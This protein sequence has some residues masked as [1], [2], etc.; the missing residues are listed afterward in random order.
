M[1]TDHKTTCSAFTLVETMVAL[2]IG[3]MVV[4]ATLAVY[5]RVRTASVV[6]V[7]QM[8]RHRLQNEIL[9]K[10][11]EDIDRLAAP[12]FE[13]T[14]KFANR[15]LRGNNEVSYASAEL[16]LTNSYYGNNDQKLL[17]EE[18][19]W[20]TA[21][22]PVEDTMILYRMHRGL[23]A[24]DPLFVGDESRRMYIPVAAGVTFFELRTQHGENILAAWTSDKLPKAV[25]IG[26]SFA[27]PVLLDG[28]GVG[29]ADDDIV[30]RTVAVDRS[31]IIPYEL[32]KVN[33]DLGVLD[34]AVTD[35]PNEPAD[36]TV[37]EAMETDADDAPEM[38]DET[39]ESDER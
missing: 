9:Q 5:Q 15:T 7:E 6:I 36:D 2:V 25:R 29:V 12:G 34:E 8:S 38:M 1:T 31:R 24:E 21:Y 11:A 18:V 37:D 22:D 17:Y 3:A 4:T 10:M 26:L 14:M 28:G 30:Y 13:A 32:M 20:R 33:L 27:E 19:V 39:D 35:D 23:N 16:V